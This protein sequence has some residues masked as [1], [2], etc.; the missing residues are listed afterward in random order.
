MFCIFPFTYLCHHLYTYLH[1]IIHITYQFINKTYISIIMNVYLKRLEMKIYILST[2][3]FLFA[4][5]IVVKT[6]T[7]PLFID[8]TY[9]YVCTNMAFRIL[10]YIKRFCKYVHILMKTK[11]NKKKTNCLA[12]KILTSF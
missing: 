9:I 12:H 8:T 5:Q 3:I 11:K 7:N 1:S 6:K 10:F 2:I 4:T